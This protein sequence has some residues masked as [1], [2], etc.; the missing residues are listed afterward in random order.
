MSKPL[1]YETD[2]ND[3]DPLSFKDPSLSASSADKNTHRFHLSCCRQLDNYYSSHLSFYLLYTSQSVQSNGHKN[4]HDTLITGLMAMR[5]IQYWSRTQFHHPNIN[6]TYS[7]HI[8][9][10]TAQLFYQ[11]LHTNYITI[12]THVY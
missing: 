5:I 6:C 10:S 4:S 12:N 3:Y 11:F 7:R 8:L 9:S 1:S 2:M